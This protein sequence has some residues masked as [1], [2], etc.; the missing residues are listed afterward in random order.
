MPNSVMYSSTSSLIYAKK[1]PKESAF[2]RQGSRNF[3][4]L[5]KLQ[6]QSPT[7]KKTPKVDDST[8]PIRKTTL[9]PMK[10]KALG[11]TPSDTVTENTARA[12]YPASI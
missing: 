1:E 11:Y 5:N 9:K 6:T 4:R 3:I 8:D 2:I 7:L 12:S 10:M